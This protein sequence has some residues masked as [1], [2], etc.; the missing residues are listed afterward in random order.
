MLSCD[1]KKEKEKEATPAIHHDSSS[2]PCIPLIIQPKKTCETPSEP[3]F[4]VPITKKA[5]PS[6]QSKDINH[7]AHWSHTGNRWIMAAINRKWSKI[8]KRAESVKKISSA[9]LIPWILGHYKSYTPLKWQ[10][11]RK[12]VGPFRQ[13]LATKFIHIWNIPPC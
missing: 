8:K 12:S 5:P 7:L 6:I 2:T 11:W 4:K 1:T 13:L 10:E 9:I 3:T